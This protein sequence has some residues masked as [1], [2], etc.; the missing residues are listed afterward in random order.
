VKDK[1]L[2]ACRQEL[3]AGDRVVCAL[4]GGGD[5]VALLHGLLALRETLGITV[6]AAH[7]NHCLRGAESDGDEAF[8]R[9]LC[10]RWNVPLAVGRGDPRSRSGESPEEAARNLRYEFLLAQEGIL[11][12]A[13][14][15]D[16]QIETVL[17]NLLRG[18]GL[19]GLCGMPVRNGRIFRPLLEVSRQEISTYL[20]A[21]DL[22]CRFD[23]S[24]AADD[25][26][27]N[28]LRHHILPL[29]QAENPNLTETFARMTGLLQL[30]EAFLEEKTAELLQKSA[31]KNGFS[32][33]ILRNAPTVLRRRAIRQLLPIPKPA[34]AHVEEV[35]KLL[36]C[37]TGSASIDLPG[38]VTA[39]REYELLRFVP[40]QE[41]ATFS[42][43]RLQP[44]HAVSLPDLRITMT[45]PVTLETETDQQTVFAIK[46]DGPVPPAITVRPR[47]TDDSLRLSGG[48][49]SLK[50]LMIDR[51]IPAAQ[52]ARLPVL[53]DDQGVIAVYHLG[54]DTAR[55]ARSGD[56]AWIIQFHN[57]E[58]R[59]RCWKK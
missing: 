55:M 20:A 40:P 5:S 51:K 27:R 12:T 49:K 29:L 33:E 58:E 50:K 25:A 6:T 38:G 11:A 53:A 19:K 21:H 4:S 3:Q 43:V 54:C 36:A 9:Q 32:A 47:Q 44:D 31:E 46:A 41:P 37:T 8:V 2:A 13:H 22:P 26:L 10:R 59:D 1:L 52:R 57:N 48:V 45:G 56:R 23:S 35:E 17:L 14:H 16:D 7:F 30:D 18:T 34:M 42:P 15:G 24:N 28:R 39:L